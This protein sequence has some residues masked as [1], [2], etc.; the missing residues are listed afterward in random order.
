VAAA[1]ECAVDVDAI[2]T[3]RQGLDRLIEQYR[4]VPRLGT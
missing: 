2:G 1:P 4:H 3:H